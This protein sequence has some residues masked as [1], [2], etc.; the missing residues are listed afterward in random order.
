M[1]D[2][3]YKPYAELELDELYAIMVLRQRVFVVEQ[4]CAYLDADGYDARAWHLFRPARTAYPVEACAYARIFAPGARYPEAAIGRI[5]T[6]PETRKTG[7][8]H[9]LVNEAVERI[10]DHFGPVAIRIGAQLRLERFYR[11]HGFEPAGPEYVEDGIP[12]IEMLRAA[13]PAA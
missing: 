7:L 13:P 1:R 6:A 4:T 2:W 3:I 11:E 10:A 8:G 9:L 12:H 5:V